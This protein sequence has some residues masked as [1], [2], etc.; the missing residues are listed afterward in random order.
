MFVIS[1]TFVLSHTVFIN[2]QSFPN[3]TRGY[4]RLSLA[5]LA[6][7]LAGRH[8]DAAPKHSLLF[9]FS[10]RVIGHVHRRTFAKRR[11]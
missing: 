6:A 9:E 1:I 7:Q 10:F 8:I 3:T 2:L 11:G 4:R 5:A